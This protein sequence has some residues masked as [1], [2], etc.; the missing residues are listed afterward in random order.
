MT[1]P[2]YTALARANRQTGWLISLCSLVFLGSR[3]P[4]A[5]SQMSEFA[6]WWTAG[7][8]LTAVGFV[9]L[10]LL[11][12]CLTPKALKR[13]WI[14]L[15]CLVITLQS[16]SYSAYLVD[17]GDALP[18]IWS[19]EPAAVG[20]LA[21]VLPVRYAFSIAVF[22]GVSVALSAWIFT[23]NIPLAV[24]EIT[25]PHVSNIAFAAIFLGIRN[26]LAALHE[27]EAVVRDTADRTAESEAEVAR[28]AELNRL[29]H[30][31]V[32]SVF[33]AAL[34]FRGVPPQALTAE[35]A[36]ALNTLD[37]V[38]M[39]QL[40]GEVPARLAAA[41]VQ[42]R[43]TRF[44][45]NVRF[46]LSHDASS[47]PAEILKQVTAAL[48]EA[49]RNSQRHA[50]ASHIDVE[51]QFIEECIYAVVRDDGVGMSEVP[52]SHGH[53]RLGIRQSIY[54]RMQDIGGEA[55][56]QTASG[57]GTRVSLTWKK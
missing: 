24:L 40:R 45:P 56:I 48:S 57:S 3:I 17:G 4:L 26:R 11:G 5:V 53:D 6:V 18:W 36:E 2:V 33:S 9:V 8:Y 20:M 19:L 25:P 29:V 51:A 54:G 34:L 15:P 22:S 52:R 44:A 37:T 49:I 16:F 55:D 14:A 39:G 10:A 50:N 27:R 13:C 46:S 35:A 1:R 38:D 30:D 7:C 21:L 42:S 41:Q 28:R 32:L 23:G 31:E 47:V 12:H 43:L